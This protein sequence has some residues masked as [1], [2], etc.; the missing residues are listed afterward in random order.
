MGAP[1]MVKCASDLMSK[2]V[3][4][5]EKNIARSFRSA[6]EQGAVLLID[7]VDSFLQDRRGARASWEAGGVR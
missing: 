6:E 1:L 4:D 7:E 2:W 3:G 5:T